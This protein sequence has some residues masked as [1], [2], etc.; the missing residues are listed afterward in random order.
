MSVAVPSVNMGL[1]VPPVGVESGPD[2][3]LDINT[4]LTLIDQHD[5]TPGKGIQITPAGINI[6]TDLSFGN[7]SA[8]GV[9]N[10]VLNTQASGATSTLQA[11]SVA[12]GNE[13]PPLQDLWYTDSA[14]NKVQITSGGALAAVATTVDGI[15]YALG[16][17]S[18]RQSPDALPTTP[19]NLDAGSVNIRPNVAAT[20]FGV[21]LAPSN[22]VA[23]QYTLTLPLPVAATAFVTQDSSGILS[24]SIPT[25]AGIQQSNLGLL[26][27]GNPQLQADSVS[28]PQYVNSSITVNKLVGLVF[29]RAAWGPSAPSGAPTQWYAA[30]GNSVSLGPGQWR[31]TG[32]VAWAGNTNFFNDTRFGWFGANGANN[33]TTPAALTVASLD[34]GRLG[35]IFGSQIQGTNMF[36]YY[37][38]APETIITLSAGSTTV[39]LNMFHGS[40]TGAGF[41]YQGTIFAEQIRA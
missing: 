28:T 23:S 17:F 20:P 21:N 39:F 6:N 14:G 18:F 7:N 27:V 11:L 30:S 37:A 41:T 38:N 31:L 22:S 33:S 5:H 35:Q 10:V 32:T 8:T 24:G 3:A 4:A 12:P 29:N 40:F 25:A 1:P 36:N 16:T 19:A 15:S 13:G 9:L 2:Y 26:S 34:G